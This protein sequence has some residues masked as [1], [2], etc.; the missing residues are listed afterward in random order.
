MGDK[1]ADGTVGE[2]AGQ[3]GRDCGREAGDHTSKL[4]MGRHRKKGNEE[5]RDGECHSNVH[6]A[7]D[8]W[9]TA[10]PSSIAR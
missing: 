1:S 7:L 3:R 5:G 4:T 9:G 6:P 2:A 8:I 10:V